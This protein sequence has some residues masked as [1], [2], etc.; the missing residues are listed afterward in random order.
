MQLISQIIRNLVAGISQQPPN[1]RHPEQLEEQLNGLSTEASG[2]QK[3]P[4]TLH[5]GALYTPLTEV[6]PLIHFVKRDLNEKYCFVLTGTGVSIYDLEGNSKAVTYEGM[7]Q[8]YLTT[9][10]PRRDLKCL[11]I[12]DYTFVTNV[13]KKVAM[14]NDTG[15]DYY[16][17]QG[18]LVNVKSGQYGRTYKVILN[19]V[20]KAS[21]T[22]P[23]G[24]QASHTTQI[25]TNYIANQLATQL[26]TAGYTVEVGESWVHIKDT[27]IT[28]IQ[29]KDGYNNQAMFGI[30]KSVQKFSNLPATAPNNFVCR[31]SGEPSSYSDDYYVQYNAADAVW[32]ECVQPALANQFDG[33]TMPYIIVR[34]ADG[35]FTVKEATWAKRAAG[36][37]DSNPVPSF[38]GQTI[39]D[40]FFF[41]NRLGFVAGENVILSRS[42]EFF[43]FWMASAVEVLD[44][45][46]I[47]LAVSSDSVATLYHAVPFREE[48]LLFSVDA[49][50][51]LKSDG[52]L[53]PKNAVLNNLTKFSSSSS[54]KPVAAGKN[55]Y[56]TAPRSQYTS[57]KEYFT[58]LE[59]NS[60]KDAQDVTSHVPNYIPNGVYKIATS[61]IENIILFLTEG[62][63]DTL[64]VY[65]YLF[66]DSVRQQSAWSSWKLK[67]TI[68]G[69]EFI[70]AEL[71]LII[72][73]GT[74]VYMEKVI[75]VTNTKDYASEPFRVYMDRK[76]ITAPLTASYYDATE[77]LTTIDLTAIYTDLET[78][79][80][81]LVTPEGVFYRIPAG[82]TE[83]QFYGDYTG[84]QIVLGQLYNLHVVFSTLMIKKQDERGTMAYTEG[85]LQLRNM[86]LTYSDSTY[87]KVTVESDNKS[88]FVYEMTGKILDKTKID[89]TESV[90]GIFKFPIQIQN[91]KCSIT[92]DSDTPGAVTLTGGGWDA[93]Y[94][95]RSRQI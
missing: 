52:A 69:A 90:T 62:A 28:T 54:V 14:A 92:V 7:A 58:A 24:S 80:H 86:W 20:E 81:G 91:S 83:V 70:D 31:V 55:I 53:S 23:D 60:Q 93:A 13:T 95:R 38:V 44:T 39:N 9:S 16:A 41:R 59:D 36:D 33:M 17:L 18:A 63:E 68:L 4:P 84:K 6:K 42:A 67:G 56:F 88:D 78:A 3:R 2:L 47:D 30:L 15:L 61:T 37:I 43:D 75:F 73:H 71:Y 12:A 51:V 65:K 66:N 64:Y 46:M 35:S 25:D 72:K 49:Q 27:G 1:L 5:V 19:G 57:V 10:N 89:Y 21:F 77:N 29:T 48:L 8:S 32:K 85:R 79:E 22:T 87:F 94:Y 76:T 74:K 82:V 11:T 26:T 34:N 50:F 40:V 45:D